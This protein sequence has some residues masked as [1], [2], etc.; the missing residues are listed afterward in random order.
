MGL[1]RVSLTIA[2]LSFKRM[3][4]KGRWEE[5]K[6]NKQSSH[7]VEE[8]SGS[9]QRCS[10]RS[11]DAGEGPPQL[12][13]QPALWRPGEMEA[14]Q[15]PLPQQRHQDHQIHPPPLHPHEPLWAVSPPGKHLLCG[16]GYSELYPCGECFPARGSSD[17]HLCHSVS[18][19]AEGRLGGLQEVP[20][21][22][23]AQQHAVLHLQQV[24][25]SK[26][27]TSWI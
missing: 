10:E 27:V 12:G 24:T 23:E 4:R 25:E 15:P 21:R 20:V 26:T 11:K 7:D 14:T 1:R 6:G 8:P 5:E 2:A 18:D 13:V 3:G 19:C 9:G 22:Q 16:P 17:P